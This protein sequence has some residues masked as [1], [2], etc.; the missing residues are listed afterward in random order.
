MS[1]SDASVSDSFIKLYLRLDKETRQFCICF[2]RMRQEHSAVT[3][4]PNNPHVRAA[5]EYRTCL[6]GAA[7]LMDRFEE[8]K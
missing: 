3:R 8:K 1:V 7:Y 6:E 5:L 2:F 4:L